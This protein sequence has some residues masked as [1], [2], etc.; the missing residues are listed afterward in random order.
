MDI[1]FT[2]KFQLI[3]AD[4]DIEPQSRIEEIVNELAGKAGLR[5]ISDFLAHREWRNI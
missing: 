1:L 5:R 2:G 4:N 3:T